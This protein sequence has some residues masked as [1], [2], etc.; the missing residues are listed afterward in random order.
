MVADYQSGKHQGGMNW[1]TLD[2]VHFGF[3][4]NKTLSEHNEFAF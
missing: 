2:D 3:R 1:G 4:H